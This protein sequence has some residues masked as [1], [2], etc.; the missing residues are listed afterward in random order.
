M[1]C[2]QL[3]SKTISMSEKIHANCQDGSLNASRSLS[4]IARLRRLTWSR[5]GLRSYQQNRVDV[6]YA[7]EEARLFTAQAHDS[8]SHSLSLLAYSVCQNFFTVGVYHYQSIINIHILVSSTYSARFVATAWNI[9]TGV[10]LCSCLV[11]STLSSTRRLQ[12]RSCSRIVGCVIR[13]MSHKVLP[14]QRIY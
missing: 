11:V 13:A 3:I 10:V 14:V 12:R 9:R 4:S 7:D 1:Q 2:A 5:L 8:H 6:E